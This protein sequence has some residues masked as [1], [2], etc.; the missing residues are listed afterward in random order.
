MRNPFG[1]SRKTNDPYAIYKA[2]GITWY[3]LKTYKLAKNEDQFSRWF[4]AGK[5]DATFGGFDL[6]DTYA[7]QV[8]AQGVLVAAT[9]E[10]HEAYSIRPVD[11][12]LPTPTEY[13]NQE[14]EA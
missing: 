5:S 1:R 10:W 2:N 8:K 9:P 7:Y 12:V 3:V 13:L 11:R 4:V 6:G 14:E